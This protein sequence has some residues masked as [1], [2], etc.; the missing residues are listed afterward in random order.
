MPLRLLLRKACSLQIEING[1]PILQARCSRGMPIRSIGRQSHPQGKHGP[2]N[3]FVFDIRHDTCSLG[4]FRRLPYQETPAVLSPRDTR[5][6][7]RCSRGLVIRRQRGTC[8][9]LIRPAAI[10]SN[11]APNP[12]ARWSGGKDP[13]HPIASC[14]YCRW[15]KR[16]PPKLEQ[17]EIS[18]CSK[19]RPGLPPTPWGRTMLF[20]G[21]SSMAMPPGDP[22]QRPKASLRPSRISSAAKDRRSTVSERC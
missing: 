11:I 4:R 1:S 13:I 10:S 17:V 14:N 20:I 9:G 22:R 21:F 8:S 7:N 3:S 2:L 16:Q 15:A 6:P 12:T 18:S 5:P 19:R